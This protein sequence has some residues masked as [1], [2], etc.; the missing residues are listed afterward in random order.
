MKKVLATREINS[1]WLGKREYVVV[2][3]PAEKGD[4]VL[5]SDNGRVDKV[6]ITAG[7]WLAIGRRWTNG[8]P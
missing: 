6:R 2:D 1:R 8:K 3:G 5:V 7:G 4:D